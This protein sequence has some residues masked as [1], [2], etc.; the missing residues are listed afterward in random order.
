MKNPLIKCDN[1]SPQCTKGVSSWFCECEPRPAKKGP[2]FID[3]YHSEDCESVSLRYDFLTAK[4]GLLAAKSEKIEKALQMLIKMHIEGR[5]LNVR[6]EKM[7]EHQER[8]PSSSIRSLVH[9]D[10]FDNGLIVRDS[11][12]G[13]DHEE[14]HR[15]EPKLKTQWAT[16]S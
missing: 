14:A 7:E 9:T 12:D 4:I 8:K 16:A 6:A 15:R 1:H 5:K 2:V 3:T 10:H 13:Q 11:D